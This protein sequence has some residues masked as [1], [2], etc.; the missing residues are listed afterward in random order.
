MVTTFNFFCFVSFFYKNRIHVHIYTHRHTH[1]PIVKD[2]D[3]LWKY[4]DVVCHKTHHGGALSKT[5]KGRCDFFSLSLCFYLVLSFASP[6]TPHKTENKMKLFFVGRNT[7][8]HQKHSLEIADH[9]Q[10]H[11][12][13]KRNVYVLWYFP[14]QIE[15][16]NKQSV[17]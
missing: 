14:A 8:I 2:V 7:L 17:L 11:E 9:L 16:G 6:F 4:S 1:T 5:V 15:L 10:D 3:C 12:K 13:F